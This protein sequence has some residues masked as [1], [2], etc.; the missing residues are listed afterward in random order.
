MAGVAEEKVVNY[1]FS[2][3]FVSYL[4][5]YKNIKIMYFYIYIIFLAMFVN[6]IHTVG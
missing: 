5:F 3:F 6:Y 4:Y 2:S 1:I